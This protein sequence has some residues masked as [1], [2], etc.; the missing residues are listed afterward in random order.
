MHK[1]RLKIALLTIL[2]FILI[3]TYT[4]PIILPP[5]SHSTIAICR[6]DKH[7]TNDNEEN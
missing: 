4:I 5:T 3:G 7:P 1:N 2:S 6:D